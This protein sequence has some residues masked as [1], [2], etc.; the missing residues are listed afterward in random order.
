MANEIDYSRV[1]FASLKKYTIMTAVLIAALLALFV[2][3]FE[4]HTGSDE[5]V[6]LDEYPVYGSPE[7]DA[8]D[9][10]VQLDVTDIEF[11]AEPSTVTRTRYNYTSMDTTNQYSLYV[12]HDGNGRR[13]LMELFESAK[14]N[15]NPLLD[16]SPEPRRY[17]Q[18][19]LPIH[20]YGELKGKAGKYY[21][22]YTGMRSVLGDYMD[23][24]LICLHSPGEGDWSSTA[25][26]KR[27]VRDEQGTR[28]RTLC[29]V[30]MALCAVGVVI[31]R[32]L[33]DKE[34]KRQ[35]QLLEEARERYKQEHNLY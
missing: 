5:A 9:G 3:S 8:L 4:F 28:N 21:D 34:K 12:I 27:F 35:I 24:D 11:L 16:R 22:D 33:A 19:D 10:W 26:A 13:L 2:L 17:T 29:R 32:V 1:R 6:P 20:L 15:Y 14:T 7:Q 31:V 30:G 23:D 18:A 25:R